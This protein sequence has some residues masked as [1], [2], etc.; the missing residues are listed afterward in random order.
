[1]SPRSRTASRLDEVVGM[2]RRLRPLTTTST[3]AP[4]A[5]TSNAAGVGSAVGAS[6]AGGALR[7]GATDGD[8]VSLDVAVPAGEAIA[9]GSGVTAGLGALEQA[10][11]TTT[12]PAMT[13]RTS[14]P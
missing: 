3:A 2:R 11:S 12:R 9:P 7:P 1:M 4:G 14:P 6:E 10:A 13:P 5:R 8:A